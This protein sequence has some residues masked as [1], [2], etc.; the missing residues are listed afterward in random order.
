MCYQPQSLRLMH[1]NSGAR[2]GRPRGHDIRRAI[3]IHRLSSV[4]PRPHLHYEIP[5]PRSGFCHSLFV[6]F[7]LVG[8]TL[9]AP[10]EERKLT[11]PV[12]YCQVRCSGK[13]IPICSGT[14][15]SIT[16]AGEDFRCACCLPDYGIARSPTAATR[17][18][19]N[20]V[21]S[22]VTGITAYCCS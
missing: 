3:V 8:F 16:T 22:C 12:E 7:Q 9:N 18:G 19:A 15:S 20:D 1:H 2:A 11:K 17:I 10:C 5:K 6:V 14:S 21:A 4:F 13:M